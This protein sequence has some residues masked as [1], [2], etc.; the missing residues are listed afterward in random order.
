M[1]KGYQNDLFFTSPTLFSKSSQFPTMQSFALLQHCLLSAAFQST[2]Q[3]LFWHFHGLLSLKARLLPFSVPTIFQSLSLSPGTF[4]LSPFLFPSALT[5]AGT[6][7]SMII[8]FRFFFSIKIMSGLLASIPQ[9]FHFL[10][11]SC[12]FW[13][14]FILF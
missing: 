6:A 1:T 14:M 10:I 5:S 3:I 4:L 11:F 9:H 13:D 7:V 2:H 12:S 8:P